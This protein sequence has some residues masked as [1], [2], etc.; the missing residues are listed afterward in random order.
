MPFGDV[1]RE[2]RAKK[3]VGIKKMAKDIGLNYTYI[4]KLE[5]SKVNPSSD[6]VKRISRYFDYSCD[7]LLLAAGK[8]PDEIKEILIN[9][10]RE[11][12]KYLRRKF[13]GY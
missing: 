8:I 4:S 1:L 3:G 2:L 5:N 11:A 6:V 13:L 7:E 10:P 9:N 12:A